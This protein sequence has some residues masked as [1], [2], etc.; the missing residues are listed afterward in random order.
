M[1]TLNR[2]ETKY[3]TVS[4]KIEFPTKYYSRYKARDYSA[5]GKMNAY[6]EKKY[7]LRQKVITLYYSLFTVQK[8]I[9]LTRANI[10]AV[11]EFARV[12]ENKYASGKSNQTDSM[13]AHFEL[14]KLE[15]DLIRLS[16]NEKSLSYELE[17]II[18]PQASLAI[19]L[20]SLLLKAPNIENSEFLAVENTLYETSISNSPAIKKE[21]NLLKKSERLSDVEKWN[22]AP[23][24]QF[25]YQQRYAG[26][27]EDSQIYS[28]GFS[29]PL[30]GWKQKASYDAAR[31]KVSSQRYSLEKTKLDIKSK[32]LGLKEKV[33]SDRK[34]LKVYETSLI[35]QAQAAYNSTRAA[36]RAN[37]L[38]FLDLLDSERS[39]YSV[40]TSYYESLNQYV[41]RLTRLESNLGMVISDLSK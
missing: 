21:L 36:Y 4:Q 32:L 5:R 18:N 16:E 9:E 35:P 12:A 3:V 29:L 31:N 26:E 8:K 20:E 11:K 19:N 25:Q 10:E 34:I 23:D 28:V 39:L 27:P 37:K 24:F 41:D 14:T 2:N 7:S 33:I 15:L 13:K 22:F 6:E 40:R 38:G 1:S 17:S 30:W